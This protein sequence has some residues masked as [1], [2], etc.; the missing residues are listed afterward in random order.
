ME[1]KISRSIKF[2]KNVA[3]YEILWE[4]KVK[5]TGHQCQYNRAHVHCMLDK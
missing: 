4:N 3:I 5:E 1:E 2:F